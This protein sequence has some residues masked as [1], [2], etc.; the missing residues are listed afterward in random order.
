[1]ISETSDK[2]AI[3][4]IKSLWGEALDNKDWALLLS[5]FTDEVDTDFSTYG[6]Q[7]QKIPNSELIKSFVS[8]TFKRKELKTQ[9]LYTNFRIE[10]KGDHAISKCN[11]I[12]QHFIKDFEGGEECNLRGEYIDE[13]IRTEN[14]WKINKITFH[15]F[16][17]T[18]NSKILFT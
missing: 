7:P 8:G 4:E 18:G 1:M 13:L 12:G 3:M 2:L 6:I 9:H 16:Y 17:I 5:L 10:V 15:Q 14:G 11:F